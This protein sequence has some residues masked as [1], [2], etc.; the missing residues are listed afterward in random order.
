MNGPGPL[1][2][3]GPCPI[4]G[5]GSGAPCDPGVLGPIE[6]NRHT[7]PPALHPFLMVYRGWTRYLET[8]ASN[9]DDRFDRAVRHCAEL[10]GETLKRAALLELDKGQP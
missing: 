4:C 3:P 1:A 2:I 6:D 10:L 9:P 7:V 5:A 8:G